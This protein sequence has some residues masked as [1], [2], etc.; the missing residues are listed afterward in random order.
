MRSPASQ[1]ARPASTRNA[2]LLDCDEPR[3]ART[4]RLDGYGSNAVR[5]SMVSVMPKRMSSTKRVG[6]VPTRPYRRP[7]MK[8]SAFTVGSRRVSGT[9]SPTR[10]SRTFAPTDAAT[11]ASSVTA[12]SASSAAGTRSAGAGP[13]GAGPTGAVSTG[14][15]S[16]GAVSAGA[17]SA[18]AV[19]AGAVS[20]GAVSTGAVSGGGGADS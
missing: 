19:S 3:R 6:A 12:G 14:A 15:V 18:G 5:S 9:G 10:R 20:A 17:V 2:P 8:P 1:W 7:N 16:A 11:G 4:M 13:T